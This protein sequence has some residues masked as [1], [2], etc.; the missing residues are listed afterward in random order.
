MTNKPLT[1]EKLLN[2]VI[3]DTLGGPG[4]GPD[5]CNCHAAAKAFIALKLL[6]LPIEDEEAMRHGL[7]E[8][9]LYNMDFLEAEGWP[10]DKDS[11]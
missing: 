2:G 6:N 1:V 9:N 5:A 3:I 4:G 10:R 8:D 7:R 11:V